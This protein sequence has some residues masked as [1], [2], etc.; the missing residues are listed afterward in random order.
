MRGLDWLGRRL[1]PATSGHVHEIRHQLRRRRWR[2][3]RHGIHRH[4][5]A[6]GVHPRARGR[7]AQLGTPGAGV[8]P[9]ASMPHVQRAGLSA[10]RRPIGPAPV[11]P[12]AGDRRPRRGTPAPRGRSGACRRPVDGRLR[13]PQLRAGA[14]G[15][16]A[17]GRSCGHRTRIRPSTPGTSSSPAPPLS[18]TGSRAS[19][20]RSAATTT[21]TARRAGASVRSIPTASQRSTA[22]SP[23]TRP[24]ARHSPS[25]A[26]SCSAR[27]CK[28][29][30]RNWPAVG[31]DARDR[32][33]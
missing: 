14:S 17:V 16:D 2:P 27:R 30:S 9:S 21:C 13:G 18:P 4:R 33:R 31:S 10:V 26:A 28:N 6:G 29:S 11:Q 20:S 5:D 15:Q 22:S 24:S 32:R 25:A 3:A 8:L 23:S 7:Y 19:D 1:R 12:G